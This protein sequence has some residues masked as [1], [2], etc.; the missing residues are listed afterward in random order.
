MTPKAVLFDCDGVIV[1]SEPITNILLRDNLAARGLTL[2]D[3]DIVAM[4]VGGTM[5]AVGIKAAQ[6]GANIEDGWLDAMYAS[7][8]DR[9]AQGTPLVQ[10]IEGVLDQLDAAGI[11]YAVGSN[12][13]E[14]KMQITIGQHPK[15]WNRLS[16]HLYSAHVHAKPKPEPDLYLYAARQL[17]VDPKDCVVVDDSAAGCRAAKN[18]GIRCFGY[19]EHDD[20]QNLAAENAIPFHAMSDLPALLGLPK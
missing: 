18:A 4:F 10:G 9:L 11:V 14:R 17:G 6:M 3:A 8:Y 2:T 7:M 19:A 15:L 12:G 5:H 13:N 1:D 16:G 20:G